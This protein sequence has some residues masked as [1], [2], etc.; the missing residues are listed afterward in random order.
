MSDPHDIWQLGQWIGRQEGGAA[1][2]GWAGGELILRIHRGRI[3]FVE[4]IDSSELSKRLSCEPVGHHDLLEEARALAR[5]GQIA[6]TYAMSA[7]KELIQKSL[8]AWMVDS[9]RELE[10]VEGEPD[11]VEGATISIT[12]TLVELVLSDT[13]GD[14]ASAILP[15]DDVLLVR[16]PGF[17]DLYAP[18]RLS[19]DA[20]LIVSKITGER[21]AQEVSASSNHGAGEVMRLLAGLV[22]TG[23]LEPETPLHI[24]DD[25]DLLPAED[26]TAGPRRR[27]PIS[28]ILAAAAA[29]IVA[30]AVIAFVMTRSSSSESAQGQPGG[31]TLTWALVIDMGCEP[32]DLQ[33]VLKKAQ[34]NPKA[35]RPVAADSGD[36]EQCWRL[37]W[38]RFSNRE[39]A[40]A[41]TDG[42]P[43]N[44]LRQGFD[45]HPIELTGEEI[46]PPASAGN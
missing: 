24:S 34:D 41:A 38:G 42:I 4:G 35:V 29:L 36:G 17:L 8:R 9:N 43:D 32:Q 21:T 45:P 19:E 5:D 46:E 10:V 16:S 27:L 22:V 14:T 7:A 30:L 18:L 11:D 15:T 23:I 39:A 12:H 25:V 40:E 2:L 3:R 20:D 28:W 33:R 26:V 31:E 44:L 37:V 13:S 6:E 1:R